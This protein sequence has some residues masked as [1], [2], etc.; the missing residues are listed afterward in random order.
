MVSGV[1]KV[2]QRQLYAVRSSVFTTFTIPGTGMDRQT[3]FKTHEEDMPVPEQSQP[4]DLIVNGIQISYLVRR[5]PFAMDR[6]G[7]SRQT[8]ALTY[9]ACRN[10]EMQAY[11]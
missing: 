8:T 5:R 2:A 9:T 1:W 11:T 7:S 10:R 4:I 6:H 3:V